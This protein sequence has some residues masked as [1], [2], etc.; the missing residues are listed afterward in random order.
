MYIAH[1]CMYTIH[2]CTYKLSYTFSYTFT[3]TFLT[4]FTQLYKHEYIAIHTYHYQQ[5]QHAC[6]KIRCFSHRF[7]GVALIAVGLNAP[8]RVGRSPNRPWL[9]G[10]GELESEKNQ[11]VPGDDRQSQMGLVDSNM[12]DFPSNVCRWFAVDR[13][14]FTS[15]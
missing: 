5:D 2:T 12:S 11:G 3:Y 10:H 15:S 9:F 13:F 8:W 6:T 14:L 4:H 1:I 7:F